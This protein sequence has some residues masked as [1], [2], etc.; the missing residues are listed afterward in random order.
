MPSSS[1]FSKAVLV[2]LLAILLFDIQGAI[3]K[4]MG[5]RYSVQQLAT[6]RNIFGLLPSC[7][8]LLFSRQ[9]HSNGRQLRIKQWR[10]A[11]LRGFYIAIAQFCFYL[12]IINM[13]LATATTLTFIG[14]IFITLLSIVIL[15]HRVGIWRWLAVVTG[16][17][18]VMLIV[19]PGSEIFNIFAIL[20]ICASFGY[21]LAVVSVRLLDDII[22]TATINLYAS[23]GA[24]IGS[25]LIWLF[26]GVYT[27]VNSTA[28]WL[29]LVLMGMVG[30]F[31]VLCLIHAYRLTQPGNLSP[32]EYFG[33]PFSFIL[34][35]LFF[36]EAPF[37]RLFPGVVFVVCAGLI[38]AWRE[39]RQRVTLSAASSH[40]TASRNTQPQ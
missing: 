33:I 36:E 8:V 21:S 31:A 12:S 15:H 14:P 40:T 37:G 13:E 32:F 23:V 16:F 11:L 24:L 10:L 22:P 27:P 6:F 17:F 39:R 4:Y 28:D 38:I 9:W 7:L 25:S 30:G 5:D 2:I 1:S 26:T 34:G 3:I 29:W 35:W 19:R 18:G 20:P